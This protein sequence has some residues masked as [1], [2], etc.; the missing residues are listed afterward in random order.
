M[1]AT[2]QQNIMGQLWQRVN[3]GAFAFLM[4]IALAGAATAQSTDRDQPTPL[5]VDELRADFSQDDPEYFYSFTAGPG[6]VIFTLDVKGTGGGGGVPYVYLYNTDGRQLDSFNQIVGGGSSEKLVK[7][8]SFAQPQIIVMRIGKHIGKGSYRLR[9]GGAVQLSKAAPASASTTVE[10]KQGDVVRIGVAMPKMQLTQSTSG[11][12][13]AEAVRNTFVNYLKGPAVEIVPLEAR[14]AT[15]AEAEAKEK[16]CDFI[17]HSSVTQKKGGGGGMLGRALGN[18]AGAAAVHIPYGSNA[19]E[20][21][22][23]AAATSAVWTAANIAG[24]IKAKDELSLEYKLYMVGSATPRIAQTVK[25]KA[26]QDG[27]DILSPLIERA[28]VVLLNEA[29]KKQ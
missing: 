6:E 28:A 22:A 1:M 27:E 14:L 13:P 12:D 3:I 19:G 5:K 11:F 29:T 4:L 24:S 2:R 18:I 16:R 25:A 8:V 23:R 20:A 21:A 17:L 15:E 26:T 7:R 9:I 10:P